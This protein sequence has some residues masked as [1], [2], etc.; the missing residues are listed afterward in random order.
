M[1]PPTTASRETR[2]KARAPLI[3]AGCRPQGREPEREIR[4]GVGE[5]AH[6]LALQMR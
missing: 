3:G 6:A 2:Q 1:K 4:I 5:I